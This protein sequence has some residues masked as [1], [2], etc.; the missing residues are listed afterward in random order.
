VEQYHRVYT[1]RLTQLDYSYRGCC[2]HPNVVI[3][4]YVNGKS[5]KILRISCVKLQYSSNRT[6][7]RHRQHS[8][9]PW[10]QINPHVQSID[11]ALYAQT[12][13]FSWYVGINV[14][15]RSSLCSYE[16]AKRS[17]PY[18]DS[19]IYACYSCLISVLLVVISGFS[20]LSSVKR[21]CS[22]R[23]CKKIIAEVW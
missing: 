13:Y 12:T 7:T 2:F 1:Y 15:M 19:G 4:S 18:G 6:Y 3:Y 22:Q 14:V 21:F 11:C 20:D 5:R 8:H 17:S 23:G 9:K 16:N 10:S